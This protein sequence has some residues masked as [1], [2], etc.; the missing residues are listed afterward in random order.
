MLHLC[1]DII[2]LIAISAVRMIFPLPCHILDGNQLGTYRLRQK[3][4][5]LPL[6]ITQFG[7]TWM[8][9]NFFAKNG[10]TGKHNYV[11][12]TLS[13]CDQAA[14]CWSWV[15]YTPNFP[16][17]EGTRPSLHPPATPLTTALL[18]SLCC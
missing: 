16:G 15:S 1:V 10:R 2:L 7:P 8:M 17:L 5:I 9:T 11:L 3:W 13:L 4:S 18:C 6:W 14:S 12:C